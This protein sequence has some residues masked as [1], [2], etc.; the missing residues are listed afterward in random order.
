MIKRTTLLKYKIMRIR[1]KISFM[2][3]KKQMTVFELIFDQIMK[4]F[5]AVAMQK[6]SE[7]G[8]LTD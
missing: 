5:Y 6:E 8:D 7:L 3:F 4:S 2:A 1:A